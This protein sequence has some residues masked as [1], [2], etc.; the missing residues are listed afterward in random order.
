MIISYPDH[1]AYER[2]EA[3]SAMKA[4]TEKMSPGASF[5]YEDAE[6]DTDPGTAEYGG[7]DEK[8]KYYKD[9]VPEMIGR[10]TVEKLF[11]SQTTELRSLRIPPPAKY[12]ALGN[13]YN[14]VVTPKFKEARA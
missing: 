14:Y 5:A 13:Y 7:E 4:F 11:E 9:G 12:Y 2:R 10:K 8:I 1:Y 3:L 6:L